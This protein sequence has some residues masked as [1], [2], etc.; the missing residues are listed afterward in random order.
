MAL[1]DNGRLVFSVEM[2]KLDGNHRYASLEDLRQVTRVLL[3]FGYNVSDVDRFVLDGWHPNHMVHLTDDGLVLDASHENGDKLLCRHPSARRVSLAHYRSD[4]DLMARSQGRALGVDYVS[5]CH[6][7]GHVAGGYATSLFARSGA[8][9]YVLCWDGAMVPFLYHVD[10]D[11][12]AVRVVAQLSSLIGMAYFMLAGTQPP[13]DVPVPFP[14]TLGLSGKIM[15]YVAVGSPEPRI[16]AELEALHRRALL[17]VYGTTDPARVQQDET[18]FRALVEQF[19][20]AIA[21]LPEDM[22]SD[23]VLAAIHTYLGEHVRR[24]LREA[25]EAD[26]QVSRNLCLVGGCALNIKWNRSIRESGWFDDVWVPPFPNDSGSAI[27]AACCELL[28]TRAWLEWDVYAGPH[29]GDGELNAGWTQMLCSVEQLARLLHDDAQPILY[30]DG[31]AELGPRALGHRSILAPATDPR[32][33][34]H[35]NE[36]KAREQ[37]RPVAPICL[38]HRAS[39]VFEPGTPDP[40]MLF[41]HV[42]RAEW[43]DRVPAVCHLDGTARLQT[44]DAGQEP[45]I[46]ALLSAYERLSGI[47]LLC[48]TSANDLGRGFFPDV[49]SAMRW[50]RIPRIWSAGTLYERTGESRT[51]SPEGGQG[52]KSAL[53][54]PQHRRK[55]G[56]VQTISSNTSNAGLRPTG[57]SWSRFS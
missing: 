23:D 37:Y 3:D 30:L 46:F 48:N 44:V 33:T 31:R 32:M 41:D 55:L 42:V 9:S 36:I 14:Q 2:E 56:P 6:Y 57:S 40:Y 45:R 47:P 7:A 15:A 34:S 21:D 20:A 25:V 53:E 35:L 51:G 1:V 43:Q 12:R 50:G 26:G 49:A 8:S 28:R 4:G 22:L 24:A 29:L 5:Y 10:G 18:T 39:E 17:D 16:L 13:F 19:R 52:R 27:G 11:T 38:A 54:T